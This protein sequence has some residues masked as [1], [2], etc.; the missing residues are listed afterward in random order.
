MNAYEFFSLVKTM[1]EIQKQY[2]ETKDRSTFTWARK[3]E[4]EV[5]REI[6]RVDEIMKQR[7]NEADQGARESFYQAEQQ[8]DN[9]AAEKAN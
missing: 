3:L 6:K 9:S 4:N 8:P 7:A 2:F 5:D 1:R